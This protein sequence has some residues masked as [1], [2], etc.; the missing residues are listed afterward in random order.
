MSCAGSCSTDS[1]VRNPSTTISFVAPG[2][3]GG[4]GVGAAAG[5]GVAGVAVV[6]GTA[7]VRSEE[8]TSELQ[9]RQYLVCRLLL[10]KKKRGIARGVICAVLR[11]RGHLP[12]RQVDRA[13]CHGALMR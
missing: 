9:S 11:K 12:A 13:L 8:H 1:G 5:A 3:G 2:D 4:V 10:E 7:D 6:S